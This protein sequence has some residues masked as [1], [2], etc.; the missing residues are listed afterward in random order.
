MAVVLNDTKHTTAV[1]VHIGVDRRF[2]L[3]EH[4]LHSNGSQRLM[5]QVTKELASNLS[6]SD[7][8]QVQEVQFGGIRSDGWHK[9]HGETSLISP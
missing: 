8:T 9:L 5:L 3:A 6:A 1:S 2:H 7:C 4:I